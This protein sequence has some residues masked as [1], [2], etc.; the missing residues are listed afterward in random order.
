MK[1][2]DPPDAGGGDPTNT[3]TETNKKSRNDKNTANPARRGD[4]NPE[5]GSLRTHRRSPDSGTRR[6]GHGRNRHRPSQPY[7]PKERDRSRGNAPSQELFHEPRTPHEH[8][9]AL[10]T[11]NYRINNPPGLTTARIRRYYNAGGKR[12]DIN[13]PEFRERFRKAWAKHAI[14][15][16]FE[17]HGISIPNLDQHFP[18]QRTHRRHEDETKDNHN[19]RRNSGETS[20][21]A[22]TE[23]NDRTAD[24]NESTATVPKESYSPT[25]PTFSPKSPTFSPK[26][27]TFSPK[28]PSPQTPEFNPPSPTSS[29]DSPLTELCIKLLETTQDVLSSEEAETTE[30]IR[31]HNPDGHAYSRIPEDARNSFR[32]HMVWERTRARENGDRNKRANVQALQ[33]KRGAADKQREIE[34]LKDELKTREGSQKTKRERHRAAAAE[35]A[36]LQKELDKARKTSTDLY[37]DV[38]EEKRNIKR[39][40][41]GIKKAENTLTKYKEGIERAEQ[42]KAEITDKAYKPKFKDMLRKTIAETSKAMNNCADF[43]SMADEIINEKIPLY[44]TGRNGKMPSSYLEEEA[45]QS[46]LNI[47]TRPVINHPFIH[48]LQTLNEQ[49]SR[50]FKAI[51]TNSGAEQER[52]NWDILMTLWK[53]DGVAR[54]DPDWHINK[55]GPDIHG[56]RIPLPPEAKETERTQNCI[57]FPIASTELLTSEFPSRLNEQIGRCEPDIL[58]EH[59]EG[60]ETELKAI[61]EI[62][63]NYHRPLQGP[64]K[65]T[66]AEVET[67]MDKAC[68]IGLPEEY[69]ARLIRAIQPTS[70][71]TTET[72]GETETS[73]NATTTTAANADTETSAN[74]TTTTAA[75]AETKTNAN[76]TTTTAAN[77]ET[78]TNASA[79]TTTTADEETKTG[80]KATTTAAADE[81]A[82]TTAKTTALTPYMPKGTVTD[83]NTPTTGDPAKGDDDE[84]DITTE[85]NAD[86]DTRGNINEPTGADESTNTGGQKETPRG[87]DSEDDEH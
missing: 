61:L 40:N 7:V 43:A 6:W 14:D 2:K 41:E 9:E 52:L 56:W 47:S 81:K 16:N 35:V 12:E 36:R 78:K 58:R 65:T 18:R 57:D 60:H 5:R 34:E 45:T 49:F 67:L 32:N 31:R 1:R 3:G 30:D 20:L 62:Y 13:N 4:N 28:Q 44:A 38:H 8:R 15:F 86:A 85:G 59:S 71:D 74:A 46:I 76:A 83:T 26:S 51:S 10:L 69:T 19:K 84:I 25:S 55:D 66:A 39:L 22:G 75:N 37:A 11:C 54:Y 87:D 80:A 27:P 23:D 79:T 70:P 72:D 53:H 48:T 50:T 64:L 42:H 82:K 63:E 68:N 33:L 73:A 77:A 29:P 17:R 24:T 21:A